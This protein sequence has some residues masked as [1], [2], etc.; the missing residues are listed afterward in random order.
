MR[1]AGLDGCRAGWFIVCAQAGL[2]KFDCF[3]APDFAGA[4]E[5]LAECE[6]IGVDM[7]IGLAASGARRCDREARRLLGPRRG[8]SVFPAPIRPVL[9][10]T[11]YAEACDRRQ[12]IDGKRMSL[13]AFNILAKVAEVDTAL[14]S[15]A[16]LAERVREVHPELAFAALNDGV[17]VEEPKRRRPG[18]EAR[19]RLLAAVTGADVLDAALERYRGTG[20]AR[21]DIL[22]AFA[23]TLSARRIARGQGRSIPPG[24]P[25][26]A[27]GLQMAIWF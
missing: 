20:V 10:A 7:P 3:V 14:R 24:A 8:A 4:V 6:I 23:V 9:G 2:T 19:H 18:F 26:D 13:Q 1:V 12:K 5:Q 21:D 17:P 16:G 22:D 25:R 11:T 15:G 27:A